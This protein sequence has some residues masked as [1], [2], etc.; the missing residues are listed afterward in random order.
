MWDLS[1]VPDEEEAS[2]LVGNGKLKSPTSGTIRRDEEDFVHLERESA[3]SE[4]EP[5]TG[6]V[7]VLEGHSKAVTALYFEDTCMVGALGA[8]YMSS[9]ELILFV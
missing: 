4:D 3:A 1:K 7:K 5:E 2:S 8:R 6:C 9:W